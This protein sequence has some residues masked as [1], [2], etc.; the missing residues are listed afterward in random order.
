MRILAKVHM[1]DGVFRVAFDI[2]AMVLIV[3]ELIQIPIFLSFQD[4]EPS[5][6]LDRFSNFITAF[7][8]TDLCLNFNTA[9]YE[10]GHI[11]LNRKDIAKH[12]FKG[13][14]F[15]GN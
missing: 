7:F 11:V 3:M 10:R 13:W 12:Y 5:D 15:I 8:L 1:P 2:F 9:F 14:F 4:I 6:D